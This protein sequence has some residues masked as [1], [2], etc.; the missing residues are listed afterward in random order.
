[1]SAAEGD[2][3]STG[4]GAV[5]ARLVRL[6]TRPRAVTTRFTRLHAWILRASRG[7][8]RRS[9]MLGGGQPVLSLTTTGR[10][11]GRA[12]S[13]VVAY[14][15][16]GDAYVV[17]AANLGSERDPSW[18]LNLMADPIAQVEVDG[19]R[20]A[21]RA[22]LATGD[23]AGRLW[24]RWVDRL[25]AAETF[26]GIAGREVPVVVLELASELGSQP[27]GVAGTRRT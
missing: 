16:D 9:I 20:S 27:R 8:I 4:I 5:L 6:L 24:Q 21:V 22:R 10:R 11:S 14:M 17:T 13:T 12:R 23:E 18:F 19:R 15:R 25:P 1:M 7:R 2:Q 26:R 3:R